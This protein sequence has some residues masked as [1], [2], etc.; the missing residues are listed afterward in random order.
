M[1][2]YPIYVTIDTNILES[3]KFDFSEKIFEH[4]R[5]FP[6]EPIKAYMYVSKP[7]CAITGILYSGKRHKLEDWKKDFSNDMDAV[8]RITD[9]MESYTY[10]ME[11]IEFQETSKISLDDLKRDIEGFIAPQSYYYLDKSPILKYIEDNIVIKEIN[12]KHSFDIIEA[13]QVCVH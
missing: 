13:K 3:A 10:A 6:D 1:I 7:V 11:I 4:R 8:E 12:V 5:F 9:Y 2:K